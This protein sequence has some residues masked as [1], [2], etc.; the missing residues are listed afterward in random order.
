MINNAVNRITYLGDGKAKEF[1]I[2]FSF[3]EKTDI[4]V[5]T[6]SPEDVETVLSRDYFVD[7]DKKTVTYPGYSPGEEPPETDRPP[8]LPKG[9]KLVIYRDIA[10]TQES[11]L[12]DKWPFNVIED[13]LDKLTMICQDLFYSAKRTLKLPKSAGDDVDPTLPVPK[14]N[15]G[16]GWDADGKKLVSIKDPA[17]YASGAEESAKAAAQSAAN[18][19]ASEK[20]TIETAS[21]AQI[22]ITNS[23]NDAI[24]NIQLEG[25]KQTDAATAQANAAAKSA[26]DA[27]E[28]ET[29]ADDSE[30]KA[31]GYRDQAEEYA[32]TAQGAS[33]PAWDANTAYSYPTVVAGPD[34]HTYRAIADSTGATPAD[35]PDK[36]VKL[37]VD[38]T[39]NMWEVDGNGDMMPEDVIPYST[40][41]GWELDG[42]GDIMPADTPTTPGLPDGYRE[43]TEEEINSLFA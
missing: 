27:K 24:T 12:G 30:A 25:K 33:A 34:G 11:S 10:I 9:W 3:L 8:I 29:N 4:V 32:K 15:Q 38:N 36:W 42:A 2:T 39:V 18:A 35:N 31:Q 17:Y 28:S 37:T 5:L 7:L 14:P 43:V 23:K 41:G 20:N 26:A 1:A 6:V 21:Q 16:I 22:D 19:K 13:A 40:G